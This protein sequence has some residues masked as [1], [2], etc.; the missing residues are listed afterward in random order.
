MEFQPFALRNPMKIR[1]ARVGFFVLTSH[2]GF[3]DDNG[4]PFPIMGVGEKLCRKI[5]EHCEVVKMGRLIEGPITAPQMS[6]YDQKVVIDT[7]EK[8]SRMADLCHEKDVDAIVLFMP[9]FLW[10]HLYVQAIQ[11]INRPVVLWGNDGVE[12]CQAIGLWAMRGTLDSLGGIPHR[13]IYGSPD[14]PAAVRQMIDYVEAARVAQQLKRSVIGIFGT[15]TMGMLPG[16]C[17]DIEWLRRFGVQSEHLECQSL[18]REGE[19]F[20]MKD[21]EVEYARVAALVRD[22]WK[23]DLPM[24][25]TIRLYL[26]HRKLIQQYGLDFDGVKNTFELSDHYVDQLCEATIMNETGFVSAI[27]SEPKAALTLYMMRLFLD[28]PHYMGDIEQVERRRKLI[29][30]ASLFNLA[31]APKGAD[32]RYEVRFCPGPHLEG[33]ANS[34]WT[35]HVLRNGPITFARLQ[36]IAGQY[37]MQIAR[38]EMVEPD[39]DLATKLGFPTATVGM[40]RL[41]GDVE[42]FIREIR[43]QYGCL[44]YGDVY[45]RMLALC[46]LLEIKPLTC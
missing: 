34:I 39:P 46:E 20:S 31:T 37:A 18:A 7:R 45:D 2:N 41:E 4:N 19:K 29:K 13:D 28:A 35:P 10:Q 27:S 22:P 40:S 36:V 9:N 43:S 32:G 38:G 5:E 44:I 12:C 15:L 1:K 24:Q 30:W 14:D 6:N 33:E 16:L 42:S 17:E 11:R 26:G 8:A 3:I 21:V 25:R 23:L